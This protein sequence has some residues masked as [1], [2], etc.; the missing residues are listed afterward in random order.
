MDKHSPLP[1]S[2]RKNPVPH[3]VR[4][5]YDNQGR[6]CTQFIVGEMNNCGNVHGQ[7][8]AELIVSA[9]NAQPAVVAFLKKLSQPGFIGSVAT[10]HEAESLLRE[11]GGKGR[12]ADV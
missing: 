1:W 10:H 7:P 3:I 4:V 5:Y 8:N 12:L 9:V 2:V 6:K 11:I